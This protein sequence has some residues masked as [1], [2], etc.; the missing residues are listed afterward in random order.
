MAPAGISDGDMIRWLRELE[1]ARL[2]DREAD[3]K[4][5]ETLTGHLDDIDGRLLEL[6]RCGLDESRSTLTSRAE[7]QRVIGERL[8]RLEK[9]DLLAMVWDQR[10]TILGLLTGLLG[11]VSVAAAVISPSLLPILDR[12]RQVG[13]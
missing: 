5:W 7:C 2:D 8:D 9:R 12:I 13:P 3:R 10:R 6:Q 4:R 11:V 1:K